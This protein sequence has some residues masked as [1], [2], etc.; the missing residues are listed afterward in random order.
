MDSGLAVKTKVIV[1]G[2]T[3]NVKPFSDLT[4]SARMVNA[5]NALIMASKM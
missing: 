4:K 2:D 1:G 3:E 5:Y